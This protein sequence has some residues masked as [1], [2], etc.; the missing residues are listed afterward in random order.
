MNSYR[1]D[2]LLENAKGIIVLVQHGSADDDVPTYHSRLMGQRIQEA[3]ANITYFELEG[4]PHYWHGVMATL[5][6]RDFFQE[7]IHNSNLVDADSRLG[8]F[9]VVVANPRRLDLSLASRSF[10]S[11]I[12]TPWTDRC[13]IRPAFWILLVPPLKQFDVGHAANF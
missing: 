13:Y 12:L 5:P 3:D 2:I 8:S 7:H 9:S 11:V 10:T 4:R 6:L 1:R